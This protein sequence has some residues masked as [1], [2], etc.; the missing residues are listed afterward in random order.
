MSA[1]NSRDPGPYEPDG[2]FAPGARGGSA[3]ASTD[4]NAAVECRADPTAFDDAFHKPRLAFG[5]ETDGVDWESGGGERR[6]RIDSV[7]IGWGCRSVVL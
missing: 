6:E 4:R 2:S 7:E 5:G 3:D 1:A